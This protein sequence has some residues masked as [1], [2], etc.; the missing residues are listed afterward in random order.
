MRSRTSQLE[1]NLRAHRR[2]AV[3]LLSVHAGNMKTV[4]VGVVA[5]LA[6]CQAGFSKKTEASK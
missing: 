6:E 5:V 2:Y 1:G 3:L 4:S